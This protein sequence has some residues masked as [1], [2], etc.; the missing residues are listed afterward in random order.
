[1]ELVKHV[2]LKQ[3]VE[4]VNSKKIDYPL[5]FRNF[6]FNKHYMTGRFDRIKKEDGRA[7]GRTTYV[8]VSKTI[9]FKAYAD[10]M[11]LFVEDT[12]RAAYD[13]HYKIKISFE[14]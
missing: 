10:A 9:N 11:L 3:S 4:R 7:V 6:S 2:S 13:N 5:Y 14:D 8:V 1:M 12:G